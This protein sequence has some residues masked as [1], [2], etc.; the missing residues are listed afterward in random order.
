MEVIEPITW[1]VIG[2]LTVGGAFHVM[3][4]E[5]DWLSWYVLTSAAFVVL[6]LLL[7][8]RPPDAVGLSV[9]VLLVTAAVVLVIRSGHG[10]PPAHPGAGH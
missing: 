10:S 9:A 8:L 6:L 4:L 1:L 2:L 5:R 7:L 3:V